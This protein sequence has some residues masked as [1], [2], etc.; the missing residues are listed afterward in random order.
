MSVVNLH[1]LGH[2]TARAKLGGRVVRTGSGTHPVDRAA[3]PLT[4]LGHPEPGATED[5]S[6]AVPSEVAS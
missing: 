5:T 3:R 1:F 6:P 2:A 4:F